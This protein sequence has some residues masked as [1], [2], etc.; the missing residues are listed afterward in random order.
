[1]VQRRTNNLRDMDLTDMAE[2]AERMEEV[3]ILKEQGV[4]RVQ[5]FALARPMPEDRLVAFYKDNPVE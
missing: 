2:G 3:L 4:D 1:M 5:G